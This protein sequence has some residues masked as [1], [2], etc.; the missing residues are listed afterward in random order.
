M[1]IR[2]SPTPL[3]I[4]PIG[5]PTPA[6][7]PYPVAPAIKGDVIAFLLPGTEGSDSHSLWVANIDG[8]GE[9][10]L[11]ENIDNSQGS[12]YRA[13]WHLWLQWSPDGKWINYDANDALWLVSPDGSVVRKF[14]SLPDKSKGILYD[15]SWSPDGTRIV[16]VQTPGEDASPRHASM[17]IVDVPS[18][19]FHKLPDID[20]PFDVSVS[21]TPDGRFLWLNSLDGRGFIQVEPT[22]GQV[23][24]EAKVGRSDCTS[25]FF[26]DLI[27][28][29]NGKWFVITGHGTG[30]GG[31]YFCVWGINGT[32]VS[33]V[34]RLAD[35]AYTLR[36][37]PT[38]NVLYF[39]TIIRLGTSIHADSAQDLMRYDTRTGKVERLLRLETDPGGMLSHGC[40]W[41]ASLSPD[42]RTL[43][44]HCREPLIEPSLITLNLN[45]FS[46]TKHSLDAHLAVSTEL[47]PDT[48]GWS[49]DGKTLI[50]VRQ[51]P[52]PPGELPDDYYYP[53]LI[54][55]ALNVGTGDI[56]AVSGWHEGIG[57]WAVSPVP[58]NP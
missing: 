4:V 28:S 21:W 22:S 35:S 29:P 10:R 15:W 45:T 58:V 44:A 48:T 52:H 17:G 33:P 18:G 46:I 42:S 5:Q 6:G 36:W 54:F 38:G 25:G 32:A 13:D 49:S 31:P 27:P 8:S 1:P 55:Y 43:E 40:S 7:T 26:D 41:L 30:T 3:S 56:T 2:S 14:L 24:R 19:E 11:V 20:F 50:L 39:S 9:K 34:R 16:Y 57:E 47:Y 53:Y 37:D 23:I 51:A 12:P